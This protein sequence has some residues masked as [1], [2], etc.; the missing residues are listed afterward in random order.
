MAQRLFQKQGADNIKV[1]TDPELLERSVLEDDITYFTELLTLDDRIKEMMF[2]GLPG[3][4]TVEGFDAVVQEELDQRKDQLDAL[5]Y[6][7]IVH[8]MTLYDGEWYLPEAV[9][10]HCGEETGNEAV[11]AI[12]GQSTTFWQ[13]NTDEAHQ[14]DFR[15]RSYLKKATKI[16]IRRQTNVRSALNNLDVYFARTLNALD[17]PDSLV[18]TGVTLSVDNDWNEINFTSSKRGRYLRLTGFGSAHAGNEIRIRE[19]EVRVVPKDYL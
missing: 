3:I 15:L 13:H 10:A 8:N 17:D 9:E 1:W 5:D 19:V 2:A 7:T 18:A 12:D 11:L 6:D 14:I 4:S 16:R